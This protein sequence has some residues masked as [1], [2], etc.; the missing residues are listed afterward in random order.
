MQKNNYTVEDIGDFLEGRLD[1]AE[2]QDFAEAMEASDVLKE[3]V[4]E[5]E[6]IMSLFRQKRLE[7]YCNRI[8][9]LK[10][11]QRD[12][13]QVTTPTPTK[14]EAIVVPMWRRRSFWAAAAVVLLLVVAGYWQLMEKE[15]DWQALAIADYEEPLFTGS[16][17]AETAYLDGEADFLAN[18]LEEATL[19][20]E[21][22]APGD[23][24]Y[25]NAQY[26]LG[27]V[28][29]RQG[30]YAKAVQQFKLCLNAADQLD[31]GLEVA[32]DLPRGVTAQDVEWF[33]ALSNLAADRMQ[34]G[35]MLLEKIGNDK[36]HLF[37]EKASMLLSQ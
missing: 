7:Q 28:Y 11:E 33:L 24:N 21:T 36:T 34:E 35:Q 32:D 16:K 29:F 4:R 15:P 13:T 23:S 6:A 26:L 10:Q 19:K 3:Q 22:V 1:E 25:V 14:Q 9:E 2:R 12:R 20:L 30:E 8:D 31:M 17:G 18:H 5:Q 37:Q 27:H